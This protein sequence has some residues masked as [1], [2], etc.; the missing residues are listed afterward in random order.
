MGAGS[1]QW[2]RRFLLPCL[3][4]LIG[5]CLTVE[6]S[7]S[8]SSSSKLKTVKTEVQTRVRRSDSVDT[9]VVLTQRH[10]L[11]ETPDISSYAYSPPPA[12][13]ILVTSQEGGVG[14]QENQD[15]NL[16]TTNQ[17]QDEEHNHQEVAVG[18]EYTQELQ[19]PKQ[20]EVELQV[21]EQDVRTPIFSSYGVLPQASM[22]QKK[23]QSLSDNH[24]FNVTSTSV[25]SGVKVEEGESGKSGEGESLVLLKEDAEVREE[26]EEVIEEVD[27]MAKLFKFKPVLMRPVVWKNGGAQSDSELESESNSVTHPPTPFQ[28]GIPLPAFEVADQ[29]SRDD[30]FAVPPLVPN[31]GG[32]SLKCNGLGSD[33]MAIAVLHNIENPRAGERYDVLRST[34]IRHFRNTLMYVKHREGSLGADYLNILKELKSKFPPS[35]GRGKAGVEWYVM[36]HDDT[37]LYGRNLLCYLAT[38]NFERRLILGATHCKGKNFSSSLLSPL[39]LTIMPGPNFVCKSGGILD[40]LSHTTTINKQG[41]G[42]GGGGG[43][44]GWT[45]GGSGIVLSAGASVSLQVKSCLKYYRKNW[46]YKVPAADVVFSCCSRDSHLEKIHNEGFV[47]GP[48]GHQECQCQK[49]GTPLCTLSSSAKHGSHDDVLYRRRLTYHH[50]RP[51]LMRLLFA[52]EVN[53]LFKREYSYSRLHHASAR[54]ESSK[55]NKKRNRHHGTLGVYDLDDA[56]VIHVRKKRSKDKGK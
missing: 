1:R 18:E 27:S 6:F 47:N 33:K 10:A 38:Y 36:V 37:Y 8:S 40:T 50:V 26:E 12:Q 30:S 9:K 15:H 13:F 41:G 16:A 42:G 39:S 46:N 32:P 21:G 31:N 53:T 20:V 11:I 44:L 2:R 56:K 49:Q 35:K 29:V 48:P 28:V 4:F 51:D 34:W 14:Q 7:S 23:E 45:S 19:H 5:I 22:D 17:E 25:S 24:I 3:S 43:W 55:S 54:N 52:Q